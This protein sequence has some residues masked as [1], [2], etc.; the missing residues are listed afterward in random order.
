M[1][2]RNII[3]FIIAL[4]LLVA[5]VFSLSEDILS[6]YV[7]FKEAME[8]PRKY[9]QIIGKLD[10]TVPVVHK[11]G[12]YS[13]TLIDKEGSK[14][15]ATHRGTKPQNFEHTDQVVVLGRYNAAGNL[16]EADKVLVKCPSKYRSKK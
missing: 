7:P 5:A 9:V 16:F 11:E 13:F 3:I 4:G 15:I 14:M 8:S 12:E 10:K 2:Y 6:P 1:K